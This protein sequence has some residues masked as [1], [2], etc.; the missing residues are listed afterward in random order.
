MHEGLDIR[1]DA[2]GPMHEASCGRKPFRMPLHRLPCASGASS[3]QQAGV[4]ARYLQER[5]EILMKQASQ[6]RLLRAAQAAI[7]SAAVALLAACGGGG[8]N[9]NNASSTPPGGVKLQ[10]VSFGTSLSD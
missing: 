4:L 3:E 2:S 8:D 1:P 9:N 10:V 5:P 6:T 7:A